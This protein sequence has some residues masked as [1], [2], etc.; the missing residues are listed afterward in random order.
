MKR[1]S[2][3]YIIT[4]SGEILKRGV[5]S[6]DD[7]GLI[8]S[9]EDTG[10]ALQERH[11]TE[12]YDGIIIPGFVNC[13]CH[14]ELSHMRGVISERTGLGSFISEVR[15]SRE[16]LPEQIVTAAVKADSEMYRNGVELCA[17]ICNNNNTFNL[18]K[19]S[20]VRYLNL[21]EVF[22][23]DPDKAERKMEELSQLAEKADEAELK[24]FMVPH[25][26]YSMSVK[27]LRLLKDESR[28]NETTSIHFMETPGE[29]EFIEMKSGKLAETYNKLG[30]SSFSKDTVKS[31]SDAILDEITTSGNLI[32]VHNTFT[33][34]QTIREIRERQRLYWCLCPNS[35][36]YIENEVPPV[37]L[38][39]EEACEIVI[40]TDSLA[41]NK[42]L[43]ILDELKSLQFHFAGLKIPEMVKWAT[44]NGARALGEEKMFGS[45]SPGKKP[46]LLL[47]ENAD[48]HNLKLLPESSVRR[49]I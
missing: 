8:I 1:F 33:D 5:I 27:L 30:L 37:D 43:D 9:V 7:N 11:S 40:G 23:I 21:L 46:G 47:I 28:G 12:F 29:K 14:L 19:K 44:L 22:G 3:Q 31:H 48:L 16:E 24:W 32:L 25:A 13:H 17:D 34:R 39:L 20:R 49:L 36:L 41:S 42:K 4:N 38:L 45:I 2:A 6:T 18:K 15:N 26:A 35:N 10:G